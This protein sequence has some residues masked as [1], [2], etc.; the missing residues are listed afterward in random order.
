MKRKKV[1]SDTYCHIHCESETGRL[2]L[3]IKGALEKK[4]GFELKW[5][6]VIEHLIR[7]AGY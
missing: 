6:Q 5:P 7:K 4:G 1:G 2:L 3:K